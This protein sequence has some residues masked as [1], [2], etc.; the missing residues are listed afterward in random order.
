MGVVTAKWTSVKVREINGRLGS[1]SGCSGEGLSNPDNFARVLSL[2]SDPSPGPSSRVT[3]PETHADI[4]YDMYRLRSE[5]A[6]G[7][8]CDL[9]RKNLIDVCHP[10]VPEPSPELSYFFSGHVHTFPLG[11]FHMDTP[12]CILT[13][14]PS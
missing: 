13:P 9:A 11:A 8:A 10:V 7:S 14:N 2:N 1:G 6:D 3:C 4:T 5:P 12:A